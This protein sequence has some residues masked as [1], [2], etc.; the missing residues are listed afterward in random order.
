[1]GT[2]RHAS[3]RGRISERRLIVHRVVVRWRLAEAWWSGAAGDPGRA[4]DPEGAVGLHD[5]GP[6]GGEGL[7]PVVEPAQAAQIRAARLAAA[8]VRD[9][10]VQIAPADPLPAV[11]EP[12]SPVAVVT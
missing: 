9:H 10:V 5:E 12:A 4:G 8:G 11:G 1:M 2:R 6:A 7:Q 3:W